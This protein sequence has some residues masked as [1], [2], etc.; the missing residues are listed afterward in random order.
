[1]TT[2]SALPATPGQTL[3]WSQVWLYALTRPSEQ[4]YQILLSDPQAKPARGLLWVGITSLFVTAIATFTQLAFR[5]EMNQ[6]MGQLER[7]AGPGARAGSFVFV[8][9]CITPLGAILAM[10]GT[11]LYTALVNLIA[12][13]LGGKGN[14][15]QLVYLFSAITAPMGLASSLLGIIPIVG[16]L[17]LPLGI[18]SLYLQLLAVKTVHQVDW[19]R[20]AVSVFA[21]VI[22]VVV[23]A[24]VCAIAVLIPVFGEAMRG[25]F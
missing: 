12:G 16:C 14:F 23:I 24:V 21:L 7:E 13:A 5:P 3:P 25:S 6:L 2:P 9:L 8:I 4:S 10:L 11:V 18:Y 22:V 1:M 19:T 17:T 15:N 20:A